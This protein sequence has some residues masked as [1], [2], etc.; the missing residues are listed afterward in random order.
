MTACGLL[1]KVGEKI[2]YDLR[3]REDINEVG[4][5]AKEVAGKGFPGMI[6]IQPS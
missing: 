3:E 4:L 5:Q 1:A 6:Q 2:K